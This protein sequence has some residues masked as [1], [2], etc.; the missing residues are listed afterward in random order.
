MGTVDS[1][2]ARNGISMVS[3]CKIDVESHEAAVLRGAKKSL[4]S[5]RIQQLA[6]EGNIESSEIVAEFKVLVE[7]HGYRMS[8]D[9]DA[10]AMINRECESACQKS[11]EIVSNA[12]EFDG[13]IRCLK[14]AGCKRIDARFA[15]AQPA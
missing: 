2:L 5:R 1:L 11:G 3:F 15:H 8:M 13:L 10:S 4:E 12:P 14:E 9:F 6:I 7:T